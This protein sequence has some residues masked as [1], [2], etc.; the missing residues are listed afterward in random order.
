M[1]KAEMIEALLPFEDEIEIV[2]AGDWE[3][4]TTEVTGWKYGRDAQG[5]GIVILAIRPPSR[6]NEQS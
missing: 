5:N 3:I 4:P 6:R 2:V 1:T